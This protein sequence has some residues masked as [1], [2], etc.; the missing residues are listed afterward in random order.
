M[1]ARDRFALRRLRRERD[2]RELE[3]FRA[4]ERARDDELVRVCRSIIAVNRAVDQV[5]GIQAAEAAGHFLR[6]GLPGPNPFPLPAEV[7]A[8]ECRLCGRPWGEH[9]SADL[10]GC[11]Y[12]LADELRAAA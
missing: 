3:Q 12:A 11:G 10:A 1:N 8:L 6:Q 7:A 5:Q 9:S 2:L 4:A